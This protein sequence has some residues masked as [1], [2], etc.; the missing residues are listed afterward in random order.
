[1]SGVAG[2]PNLSVRRIWRMDRIQQMWAALVSAAFTVLAI[3]ALVLAQSSTG[4]GGGGGAPA[5]TPAGGGG[6]LGATGPAGGAGGG[7]G[8]L[9][10]LI[11]LAVVAVIWYALSARRRGATHT[12]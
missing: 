10:L 3:P 1:L 2:V 8:W 9:W 7:S 4:P 6:G 5:G 11:A 12:R